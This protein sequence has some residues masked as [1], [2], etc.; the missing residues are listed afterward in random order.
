MHT[1]TASI[2]GIPQILWRH[3]KSKKRSISDKNAKI[4]VRAANKLRGNNTRLRIKICT[5]CKQ[6]L[7]GRQANKKGAGALPW[8]GMRRGNTTA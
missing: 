5:A 8:Q 7:H 4:R 1:E 3:K 6:D 2:S